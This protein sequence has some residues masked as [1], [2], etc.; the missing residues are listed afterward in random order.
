MRKSWP[1]ESLMVA[2]LHEFS[3]LTK[4]REIAYLVTVLNHQQM[5]SL[6]QKAIMAC[7]RFVHI[8]YGSSTENTNRMMKLIIRNA[9]CFFITKT[10]EFF[11]GQKEKH[12]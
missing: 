7:S 1:F 6:K 12:I 10:A 5:Q 2:F 8:T 9:N 11:F 4:G 3:M